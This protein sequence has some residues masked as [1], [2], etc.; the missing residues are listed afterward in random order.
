MVTANKIGLAHG[1]LAFL[2]SA[3]LTTPTGMS[4]E[5]MI[6]TQISFAGRT[7]YGLPIVFMG[8]PLAAYLV[9]RVQQVADHPFDIRA[10]QAAIV[11][12]AP[13]GPAE[14]HVMIML[15]APK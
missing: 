6:G 9:S 2:L 8:V 10:A 12:D 13:M 7:L 3:V 4:R 15:P 1:G 11:S 5:A 14:R